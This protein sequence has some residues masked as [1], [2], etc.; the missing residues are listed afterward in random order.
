MTTTSA[1][2]PA[3]STPSVRPADPAV[4]VIVGASGDLTRR[5]LIPAVYNLR[6]DGMMPEHFAIVGVARRP[7]SDAAF[8]ES[9]TADLKEF[10][11]E[12]IDGD[13][14]RAIAERL[15]YVQGDLND[16][17][18]YQR[19]DDRLPTIARDA[20]TGGNVLFYL[21]TPPSEFGTVVQHL[22]D[23]GLTREEDGRWR[24]V[25][26]EKPFGYDLASARALNRELSKTLYESQIYRIDHYLGKE[27]V[28]NILAFR[29]ANGI[30]EPIW[31]RRYVDHVQI[32]VAESV[33]IEGRGSYYDSAGAL[34]DMV[35][36][37]LFQLLAL[38]AMEPP[39]SFR[40]DD[41]RNERVKVL[42]A[43]EPFTMVRR[44]AV[45]GQY[46][47][48]RI[49]EHAI[50]AYR[51]ENGVA[52]DSTTET[53]AALRVLLENWRW[54]GVP[55]YM[56]T[57]K[58]LPR[59]VTEIAIQFKC[60]PYSLFRD[61]PIG[62]MNPNLLLLRIQPDEGIA[63]RF[64][65]KQPGPLERL[66][67]VKMDFLYKDYFGMRPSTGYETLL[68]DALIGDPTL[69]HR[70][71]IVEAGWAAVEPILAEWREHPPRNFPNYAAGTWGPADAAE[72]IAR[73]GRTWRP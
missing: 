3:V 31:N 53:F 28:Q 7:L 59:R 72:L 71:D 25:I 18:T 4:M 66:A 30:F 60:A 6:R 21:A 17:A 49:G 73:D 5:K 37:H 41:V 65:A 12:P 70:I 46:A 14:W 56:R 38:V 39:I 10:A 48:G 26:V 57:G 22:G 40:A 23:L 61:T 9:M 32:T 45:R 13:L 63:L 16:P 55:F 29:F 42:H 27:T 58:A 50:P 24:R 33:S 44:D 2:A 15:Y 67:T 19:I 8:R 1:P 34:R 51:D 36:N 54:A 64:D 69:F 11:G 43:I 47:A 20:G 52:P 68:Y 35:Q 62:C